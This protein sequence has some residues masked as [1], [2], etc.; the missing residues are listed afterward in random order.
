MIL[1]W[2]ARR[3]RTSWDRHTS[4]LFPS[5][6]HPFRQRLLRVAPIV[7]KWDT[8]LGDH[9][10]E[11]GVDDVLLLDHKKSNGFGESTVPMEALSL[12]NCG[13]RVP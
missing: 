13:S 11:V 3:T 4:H 12:G 8:A 5:G 7:I 10:I 6:M 9:P 2:D 1:E